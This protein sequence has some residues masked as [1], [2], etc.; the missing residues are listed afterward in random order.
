M[1]GDLDNPWYPRQPYDEEEA[2]EA[3][4]SGGRSRG[5]ARRTGEKQVAELANRGKRKAKQG[6][7]TRRA[8]REKDRARTNEDKREQSSEGGGEVVR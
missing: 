7:S 1:E 5:W 3:G 2:E 4:R 8:V 6:S